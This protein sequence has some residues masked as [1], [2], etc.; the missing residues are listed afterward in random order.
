MSIVKSYVDLL[1]GEI[2]VESDDA[3]TAFTVE[4]PLV[5]PAP[6]PESAIIAEPALRA[7]IGGCEIAVGWAEQR[8]AHHRPA[9]VGLMLFDPPYLL[10]DCRTPILEAANMIAELRK[11]PK[12]GDDA[13]AQLM[14]R[15]QADE[16]DAFAVLMRQ[17]HPRVLCQ[18]LHLLHD[19]QEAEDGAQ[20]VFLRLYRSRK[21]YAPTARFSAWLFHIT[22]N[23][24]RNA[25]RQRRRQQWLRVGLLPEHEAPIPCDSL[26]PADRLERREMIERVRFA[27]AGLLARQ[28]QA[29]QMQEFEHRSC[30]EIAAALALTPKAAKSLLHR[31]R[32]QMRVILELDRT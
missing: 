6:K 8:E 12:A 20:E 14:L 11:E 22:Q 1:G 28:R 15:V 10:Q 16:P 25:M 4:I 9:T 31:A 27:L 3:G 26:S 29:L 23:V 21:R 24:A 32:L 13:E 30:A 17:L 18:L 19:R 7:K 5:P 2:R